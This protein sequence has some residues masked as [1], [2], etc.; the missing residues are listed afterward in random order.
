MRIVVITDAHAN[1]PALDAVLQAIR[2]EGYDLLVHTGDAIGIGPYPAECLELLLSTPKTR[3]VM[4]NHDSYF[5]DGIPQ[6]VLASM[7]AGEI[8]HHRW[9]HS[10]LDAQLRSVVAK[11]PYV[12]EEEYAGT[13]STFVHYALDNSGRD[14]MP[15]VRRPA[16]A[17]LDR[18]FVRHKPGLIFYGHDHCA[19]DLVGQ[20]RYVNPGPLGCL[21]TPTARYCVVTVRRNELNVG[22]R[23]IAY[24]DIVLFE[25]FE[26]RQ[27]PDR[28]FI[29]KAFFGGRFP[30]R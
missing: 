7:S 16:V 5:A 19:S 23:E 13:T 29:Y 11:W 2:A 17:D 26:K 4:G 3:F 24:E 27:V 15:S 20:A 10:Q 9:A 28:G 1:L 18:A 14:Y 22:Y 8:E 30:H 6:P 12:I 25:E 21:K